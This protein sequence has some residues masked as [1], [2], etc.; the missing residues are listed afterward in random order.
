MGM[1]LDAHFFGLPKLPEVGGGEVQ[2]L[3]HYT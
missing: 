1:F 2:I 3:H